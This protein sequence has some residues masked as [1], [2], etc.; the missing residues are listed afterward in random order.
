MGEGL[1]RLHLERQRS[2]V[3]NELKIDH[4]TYSS[5]PNTRPYTKAWRNELWFQWLEM[6]AV[7]IQRVRLPCLISCNVFSCGKL[8]AQLDRKHIL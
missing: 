3:Y 8:P 1:L 6:V 2:V 5:A 7:M 4:L